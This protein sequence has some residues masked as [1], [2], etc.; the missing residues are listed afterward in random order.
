MSLPRPTTAA[1]ATRAA[2]IFHDHFHAN[3][4]Q[5]EL[6][7]NG[8]EQIQRAAFRHFRATQLDP[9]VFPRQLWMRLRQ[10]PIEQER[11]VRIKLF[12][13]L[14]KLEVGIIPRARLKHRQEHFIALGIV[15]E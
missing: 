8:V 1:L 12:L 9:R 7:V 15:G 10:F 3:F 5:R 14:K 6:I 4:L 11:N 13:E 2:T